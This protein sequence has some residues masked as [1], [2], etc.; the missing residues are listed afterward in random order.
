MWTVSP[1]ELA[2]VLVLC[3]V[4][5]Y[6][7]KDKCMGIVQALIVGLAVWFWNWAILSLDDH[8]EDVLAGQEKREETRSTG[9]QAWKKPPSAEALVQEWYDR[10]LDP[11]RPTVADSRFG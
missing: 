10:V 7:K 8:S 6:R 5:A 4:V 11:R 1:A 9:N 3:L 2:L